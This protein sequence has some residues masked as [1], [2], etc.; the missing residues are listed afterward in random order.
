MGVGVDAG[1]QE[2]SS[3]GGTD[4]EEDSSGDYTDIVDFGVEEENYGDDTDVVGGD[5][6][7][8]D[9][10]DLI[11]AA[12]ALSI[13]KKH[14]YGFLGMDTIVYHL[15]TLMLRP[16]FKELLLLSDRLPCVAS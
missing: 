5:E 2:G 4:A 7:C 1:V 16:W 14:G 10:V 8:G 15:K 11:V 3:G 9:D 12:A 13:K 6:G